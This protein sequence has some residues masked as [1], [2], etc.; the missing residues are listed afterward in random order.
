MHR[1]VHENKH[2][3]SIPGS[4]AHLYSVLIAVNSSHN[5]VNSAHTITDPAYV[6]IDHAH[7]IVNYTHL[8]QQSV[9]QLSRQR[10][11]VK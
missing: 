10:L 1:A 8:I 5:I 9:C 11:Q 2:Q 3:C 6:I 4:A 7:T